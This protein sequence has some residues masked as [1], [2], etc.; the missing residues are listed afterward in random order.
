MNG[1]YVKLRNITL[2]YTLPRSL[3]EKVFISRLRV[4]ISADNFYTWGSSKYRGFD[5]SG[6][7]ANGVQWWNFPN[8]RNVVFGVNVNF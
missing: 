6:I 3:T 7:D 8:P 1:D 5:P 2:G 4:Y